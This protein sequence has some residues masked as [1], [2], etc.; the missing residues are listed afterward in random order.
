MPAK[1]IVLITNFTEPSVSLSETAGDR[2]FSMPVR[3]RNDPSLGTG[4]HQSSDHADSM[5]YRSFMI[6]LICIAL[7]ACGTSVGVG[8]GGGLDNLASTRIKTNS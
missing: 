2:S 7:S 8:G 6:G 5:N 1:I 4:R 3:I